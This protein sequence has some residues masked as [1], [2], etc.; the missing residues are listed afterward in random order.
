MPHHET[1]GIHTS[2]EHAHLQIL[3]DLRVAGLGRLPARALEVSARAVDR[4]EPMGYPYLKTIGKLRRRRG[5]TAAER[6]HRAANPG[7]ELEMFSEP[8]IK[9]FARARH[10]DAVG[11]VLAPVDWGNGRFDLG[12]QGR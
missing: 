5:G 7:A 1:R 10:R 6:H 12:S 3:G 11:E 4:A 2:L 8:P 9:G